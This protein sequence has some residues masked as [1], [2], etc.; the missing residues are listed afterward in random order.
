MF[1]LLLHERRRRLLIVIAAL[2]LAA[3]YL[4]VL[5]PVSQRADKLNEPLDK[6]WHKLAAALNQTNNL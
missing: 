4:F 5:L 1:S 3:G 2:A 6:T